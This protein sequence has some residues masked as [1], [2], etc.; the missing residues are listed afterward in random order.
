MELSGSS[1]LTMAPNVSTF[2][3]RAGESAWTGPSVFLDATIYAFAVRVDLDC[4][5]EVVATY[6]ARP[7]HELGLPLDMRAVA[8]IPYAFFVFVRGKRGQPARGGSEERLE[9]IHDCELFAVVVPVVHCRADGTTRLVTFA[10]YVYTSA[11]PGWCADREIYGVP[12][13]QGRVTVLPDYGH[14]EQLT[15]LARAIKKFAP[16]AVAE[17]TTLLRLTRRASATNA[18][19][20]QVP[21]GGVAQWCATALNLEG[22][23]AFGDRIGRAP[24]SPWMGMT[25][26]DA[27]FLA[28]TPAAFKERRPPAP[29]EAALEGLLVGPLSVVFL[30]QFRDI[31]VADRACY[32]AIVEATVQCRDDVAIESLGSYDLHVCDI[33]SAPI[34]RELGIAACHVPVELAFKLDVPRW[35]LEN[36]R[37]LS[38]PAWNPAVELSVAETPSRLPPYV[39]R[40]GESVWRQPSRLIGARIYGFGVKVSQARQQETLDAYINRQSVAAVGVG[41]DPRRPPEPFSLRCAG[42]DVVLLLFVDYK[43]I[44]SGSD[45]DEPLG[46]VSYREFLMMQLAIRG[47]DETPTLDWFIPAIYLDSDAPRLG[48]RE[49]YGYPKQLGDVEI[50]LY[51]QA[52]TAGAPP[53]RLALRTLVMSHSSRSHAEHQLVVNI[54]GPEQPPRVEL[55]YTDSSQMFRDLFELCGQADA[56]Q[57]IVDVLEVPS[58]FRGLPLTRDMQLQNALALSNIGNV[59]LKEFRDCVEPRE[60]CY[61]AICRT[62]TVPGVFQS[63]G[64]LDESRYEI[65]VQPHASEPLF[66]LLGG[67]EDRAP[68]KVPAEFVYMLDLDFTLSRGRVM[69][70]AL[71]AP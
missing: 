36:P 47:N 39:E 26:D 9:G 23:R 38:N 58:P 51:D 11:C 59:F 45:D 31:V 22:V 8:S 27:A 65:E 12:Q 7:S 46:S 54:G 24:R 37:I 19:T 18:A 62:D 49:I 41:S 33:D 50:E 15:L 35:S 28:R 48:G 63:G 3:P 30:K 4:V 69:A 55:E 44:T 29:R 14:P 17:D 10:P 2:V 64:R 68:L 25:P 71:A 56:R 70:N 16:D 20:A 60:A 21:A 43:Q 40:G 57:R 52:S 13:Q 42:L 6:L 67:G 32:Q 66:S 34:R 53:R 1:K 61:K 5:N